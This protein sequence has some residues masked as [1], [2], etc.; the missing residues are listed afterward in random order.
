MKKKSEKFKAFRP[1]N[2]LSVFLV[3][4]ILCI[5]VGYLLLFLNDNYGFDGS[6]PVAVGDYEIYVWIDNENANISDFEKNTQ[7][8]LSRKNTVLGY[9]N[10]ARRNGNGGL[11]VSFSV[12]GTYTDKDGFMLNGAI[13]VAPGEFVNIQSG[14]DTVL[15]AEIKVIKAL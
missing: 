8:N 3:L 13:P 12:K 14:N 5:V 6:E 10:T 2:A 7:F 4:V 9:V 1:T 15:T 11:T